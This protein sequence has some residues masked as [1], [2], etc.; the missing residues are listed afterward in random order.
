VVAR[1][2]W[3]RRE[4][5]HDGGRRQPSG[6]PWLRPGRPRR[7]VPRVTITSLAETARRQLGQSGMTTLAAAVEAAANA[8]E[9]HPLLLLAML[10]R[11]FHEHEICGRQQPRPSPVWLQR[12]Q[13]TQRRGLPSYRCWQLACAWSGAPMKERPNRPNNALYPQRRTQ[14]TALWGRGGWEIVTGLWVAF[15]CARGVGCAF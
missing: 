3:T 15:G 2:G 7:A 14:D 8:N 13:G 11:A 9:P 10:G 12:T 4:A 6:C 1:R 5:F